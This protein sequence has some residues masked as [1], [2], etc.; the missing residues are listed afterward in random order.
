MTISQLLLLAVYYAMLAVVAAVMLYRALL[1]VRYY[2]RAKHDEEPRE[3]F[4]EP[5]VVTVQLPVFN[6]R[7]VVERL[8]DAVA[9][10]DWPRERLEVQLLDD[11]TDDTREIAARKVADLVARG[12]DVKHV[13]RADRNSRRATIPQAAL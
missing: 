6:E 10:L 7:F 3:R 11:S 5:P 2:R 9:A 12:F 8:L 4:V 1:V 13:R